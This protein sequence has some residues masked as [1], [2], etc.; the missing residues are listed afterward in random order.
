MLIEFIFP[1]A[2]KQCLVKVDKQSEAEIL[3]NL[4]KLPHMHTLSGSPSSLAFFLHNRDG[5]LLFNCFDNCFY[6]LAVI[7]IVYSSLTSDD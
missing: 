2:K 5:K 6:S 1:W 7:S 3:K 4:G